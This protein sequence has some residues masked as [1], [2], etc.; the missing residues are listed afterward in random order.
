MIALG[1]GTDAL[2]LELGRGEELKRVVVQRARKTPARLVASSGDVVEQMSPSRHCLFEPH[3]DVSDLVLRLLVL[4]Q[5]SGRRPD[6]AKDPEV[7]G[8]ES[9]LGVVD[10]DGADAPPAG[11]P[12]DR[13]RV[14]HIA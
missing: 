6:Q 10:R 4:P 3:R 13:D 12:G 7:V 8:G 1:I 9:V 5:Q 11:T 14:P 2:E